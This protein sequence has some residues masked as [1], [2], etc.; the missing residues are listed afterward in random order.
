[1][2]D[3]WPNHGVMKGIEGTLFA[4]FLRI[5]LSYLLNLLCP[6]SYYL[7]LIC[8][9]LIHGTILE[10]FLTQYCSFISPMIILWTCPD[11]SK[12]SCNYCQPYHKGPAW[13]TSINS[14]WLIVSANLHLDSSVTV[15]CDIWPT[16]K[17]YLQTSH[18][19]CYLRFAKWNCYHCSR[20]DALQHGGEYHPVLNIAKEAWQ[21][22]T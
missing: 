7:V 5:K 11:P 13:P 19:A 16:W 21:S 8:S 10:Y 12:S 20:P 6:L 9:C 18:D 17:S 14:C 3:L 15:S 22:R 2:L 1:M 4:F